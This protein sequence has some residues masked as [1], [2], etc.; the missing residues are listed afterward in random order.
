M[1]GH[2]AGGASVWFPVVGVAMD[3]KVSTMPVHNFG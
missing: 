3:H 2:S 1:H